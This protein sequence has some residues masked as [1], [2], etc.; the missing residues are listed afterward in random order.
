M[1]A[2]LHDG[3]VIEGK[4]DE[5]RDDLETDNGFY[6]GWEL[7]EIVEAK[8]GEPFLIF[9]GLFLRP[10]IGKAVVFGSSVVPKKELLI[11]FKAIGKYLGYEIQN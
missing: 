8:K 6:D 1:K 5:D 7:A 4:Y 9:G 3:T 2:K 10:A 11:A